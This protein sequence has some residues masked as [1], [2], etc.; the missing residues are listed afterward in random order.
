M[1]RM[2]RVYWPLQLQRYVC[3]GLRSLFEESMPRKVFRIMSIFETRQ[4]VGHCLLRNMQLTTNFCICHRYTTALNP[5]FIPLTKL[6]SW[7]RSHVVKDGLL[8]YNFDSSQD[9]WYLGSLG[10]SRLRNIW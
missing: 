8:F 2:E 7:L 6:L 5:P 10:S 3:L 4:K 1:S 9:F